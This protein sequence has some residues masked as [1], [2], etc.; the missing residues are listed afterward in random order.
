M[1]DLDSIEVFLPPT[2]RI[3][4]KSTR[5]TEGGG[6]PWRGHP[7]L[8]TGSENPARGPQDRSARP[9]WSW[10]LG[11]LMGTPPGRP[12]RPVLLWLRPG[13]STD[14][15]NPSHG[16]QAQPPIPG[17]LCS[18]RPS[19]LIHMTSWTMWTPLGKCGPRARQPRAISRG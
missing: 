16:A 3:W 1:K 19:F 15:R 4:E 18:Q 10:P 7:E 14:W 6:A 5:E 12:E 11:S 2:P 13:G 8:R 9:A 17:H